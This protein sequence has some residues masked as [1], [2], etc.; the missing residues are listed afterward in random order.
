MLYLGLEV[1]GFS[2]RAKGL[3]YRVWRAERSNW[4]LVD[5]TDD[6]ALNVQWTTCLS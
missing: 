3:K 5:V 1:Q 2:L 4:G 6:I